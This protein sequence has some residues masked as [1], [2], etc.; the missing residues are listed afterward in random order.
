MRI[1]FVISEFHLGGGYPRHGAQ[2]AHAL[3][4]R[5]HRLTILTR[6]ADYAPA[7]AGFEFLS[8]RIPN[9]PAAA[10][11]AAEPLVVTR[12]I[13]RLAPEFDAV[14]SVGIPAL[15]PMVLVG[16]GTHRGYFLSTTRAAARTSLR[17][18]IEPLRPLHRVIM[19][20]ERAMLAGRAPQRIVV[21]AKPYRREYTDLFGFPAERV[22]VIPHGVEVDEFTFD[23]A[24]RERTRRELGIADGE[25]LLVNVS[26]RPWQKGLDVLASALGRMPRERA[27]RFALAGDACNS[28]GLRRRFAPLV[29]E[30]RARLL[31][32]VP[33]VRALY[34]AADLC[35][36]PSRYDAWGMVVTEALACGLPV[37]SS[38]GI[39]AAVTVR[40]GVNGALVED[41]TDPDRVR[42]A[43][44]ECLAHSFDRAAVRATVEGLTWDANAADMERLLQGLAS[45]EPA[46][47]AAAAGAGS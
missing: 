23:P 4:R 33:D 11:M 31:G 2:L 47:G 24:L 37:V 38:A 12:A 30:G 13:R 3:A 21:G 14:V 45:E 25:A 6:R 26:G 39:G 40:P 16:P 35:V 41:P 32:R 34:C 29:A 7:D 22:A 5:G 27:W 43:I 8:Y 15:A 42:D 28:K 1:L 17:R 20:W 9:R 18:W 44:V 36:F 19:A 46:A 10:A